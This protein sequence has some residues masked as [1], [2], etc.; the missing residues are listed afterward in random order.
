M[1]YF[2]Q[3]LQKGKVLDTTDDSEEVRLS[4]QLQNEVGGKE[5]QREDLKDI[6]FSVVIADK[7]IAGLDRVLM[8]CKFSA[9]EIRDLRESFNKL[10]SEELMQALSIPW[11]LR[12]R[13]FSS[14][15]ELLNRGE[16][17][18]KDIVADLLSTA[19]EQDFTIGYH[20]SPK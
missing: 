17:K 2:E 6:V 20:V 5:L 10:S 19:R 13:V 18:A 3:N 9:D 11:E 7:I 8:D 12:R 16:I 14:Y 1:G 15:G 4:R